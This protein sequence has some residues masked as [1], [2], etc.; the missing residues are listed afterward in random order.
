V[1]LVLFDDAL[2]QKDNKFRDKMAYLNALVQE[3][4]L[5]SSKKIK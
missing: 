2:A 5:E 4:K 1:P 3:A